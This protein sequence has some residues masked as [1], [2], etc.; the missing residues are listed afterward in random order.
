MRS[1]TATESV[2]GASEQDDSVLTSGPRLHLLHTINV[3]DGAPV[4]AN[5]H[6]RINLRFDVV[7]S[8]TKHVGR[9]GENKTHVVALSFNCIYIFGANKED[10][11]TILDGESLQILFGSSD[12]L[13]HA[14]DP[15]GVQ[16]FRSFHNTLCLIDGLG[17][18]FSIERFRQVVDGVYIEGTQ[19]MLVV[20][21]N[22]N[23]QRDVLNFEVL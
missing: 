5:K 4:N 23:D 8:L 20:R 9:T 15:C 21:R 13:Q 6:P 19:G 1:I 14:E 11:L 18:P 12:L 2:M 10:C 3:D 16:F 7:Q 22:K 17:E